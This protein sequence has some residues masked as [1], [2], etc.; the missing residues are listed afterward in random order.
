MIEKLSSCHRDKWFVLLDCKS[1]FARHLYMAF[2]FQIQL[3]GIDSVVVPVMLVLT[4]LV[5]GHLSSAS[6]AFQSF[7]RAATFRP[8][9]FIADP[10]SIGCI[11][12]PVFNVTLLK[13]SC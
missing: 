4:C 2:S 12:A 10:C 7:T 11:I 9:R 6:P 1:A 5:G 13:Q 8:K 3:R